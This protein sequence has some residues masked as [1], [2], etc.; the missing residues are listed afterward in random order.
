VAARE[1]IMI[2]LRTMAPQV[3]PNVILCYITDRRSLHDD[4]PCQIGSALEAGVDLIQIRE[5]DLPTRELYELAR[6]VLSLENPAQTRILLNERVDVSRAAGAAGVH[7]PSNSLAPSRIRS[8]APPDFLVGVSCHSL[9]EVRRAEAEGADYIVFGPVF[10]TSS[11]MKYGGPLGLPALTEAAG[12]VRIPVLALGGVTLEN[13]GLCLGGGVA[14]IAGISL[15]QES[16]NLSVD[17]ATLRH[18]LRR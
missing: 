13:A 12:A 3:T 4:L 15:F 11:K 18:M 8:I 7:L 5:K 14:G 16:A 10:P 1:K 9:E 17:V 6:G 2:S